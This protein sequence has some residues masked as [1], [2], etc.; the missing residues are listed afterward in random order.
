MASARFIADLDHWVWPANRVPD[1]TRAEFIFRERPLHGDE[2]AGIELFRLRDARLAADARPRVDR[3]VAGGDHRHDVRV[4][5]IL[6]PGCG[7]SGYAAD[8]AFGACQVRASVAKPDLA[9]HA[10]IDRARVERRV[11]LV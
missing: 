9:A 2:A 5:M 10:S 1:G 4:R 11:G 6:A 3:G 8:I 7:A